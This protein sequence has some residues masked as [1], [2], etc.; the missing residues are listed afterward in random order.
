MQEKHA[1]ANDVENEEMFELS[2]TYTTKTNPG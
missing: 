1:K 2:P